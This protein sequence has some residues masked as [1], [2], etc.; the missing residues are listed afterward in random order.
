MVNQCYTDSFI[1]LVGTILLLLLV[2][3]FLQTS[4]KSQQNNEITSAYLDTA[5]RYYVD[6]S[7]NTIFK[8][9]VLMK[10]CRD[11]RCEHHRTVK[12]KSNAIPRES[13]YTYLMSIN[14]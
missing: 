4:R 8:E 7:D 2:F 12:N 13:R 10:F 9:N 3:I 6:S 5:S 1:F 14:K 11:K